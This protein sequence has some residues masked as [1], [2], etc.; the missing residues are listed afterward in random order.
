T[1][2]YLTPTT[3]LGVIVNASST[4]GNGTQ[5][6]GLTINGGATTTGSMFISGG[7]GV[8]VVNTSGG[9]IQTSNGL[10]VGTSATIPTIQGG[11][12]S[13]SVP[14][15]KSTIGAGTNDAIRFLVGNN[16]ATEA[17]RFVSNGN[18]GIGTSTPWA[19]LAI[20]ANSGTTNT[21]LFL[22]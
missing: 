11:S 8:G 6:D 22:I 19:K 7:F 4:I 18:F 5:T 10:T 21:N 13:A 3:T 17:G 14:T 16:G 2:G 15:L 1:N 12:G 9:S 20:S